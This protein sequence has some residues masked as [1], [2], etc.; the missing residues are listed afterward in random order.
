MQNVKTLFEQPLVTEDV[1]PPLTIRTVTQSR[2]ELVGGAL[3]ASSKGN[4]YVLFDVL[5]AELKTRVE[6]AIRAI[7]A[8]M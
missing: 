2:T 7:E 3:S 5:P 8:G 4:T 1:T 6:T